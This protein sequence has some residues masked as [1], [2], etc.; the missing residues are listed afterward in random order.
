MTGKDAGVAV[1][2]RL[3][4]AGW[5]WRGM[6]TG[7]EAREM[8]AVIERFKPKEFKDALR[9]REEKDF[10]YEVSFC[11]GALSLHSSQRS[12]NGGDGGVGKKTL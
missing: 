12:I 7:V 2:E 6:H 3:C 8:A 5:V 11:S 4:R 9:R 10:P 1:R